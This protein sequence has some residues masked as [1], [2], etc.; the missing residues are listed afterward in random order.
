MVCPLSEAEKADAERASGLSELD[1]LLRVIHRR[2]A[3]SLRKIPLGPSQDYDAVLANLRVAERLIAPEENAVVY[4]LI[5]R[6]VRDLAAI[7]RAS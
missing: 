4:G 6:A 5:S 3:R 2:L 7:Q 1:A